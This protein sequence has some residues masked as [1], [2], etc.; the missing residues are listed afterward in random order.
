MIRI[1]HMAMGRSLRVLWLMEELGEPYELQTVTLP[2]DDAFRAVSPMATVP[3]IVD[4]DIVMGESVAI[5]QYLTGRRLHKSLELGLT[6]G[7]VPD[8]AAYA[9]HLQFLHLGEA[10]LA[11]PLAIALRTQR[12]APEEQKVNYTSEV[13][14]DV[15][16]RRLG[17]VERQFADGRAYLTGERLTI[18]DISIGYALHLAQA[19]GAE[20]LLTPPT[21]AYLERLRARAAFQRA[22][23]A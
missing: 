2:A 10:S 12:L 21:L 6:V 5:L 1:Y 20:S 4:G 13:C 16:R 18:A 14:R 19:R 7:P 8:P 9:E 15:F 11:A 3:S 22:A 23:A 17:V